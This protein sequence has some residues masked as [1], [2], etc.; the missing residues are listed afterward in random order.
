ML[1]SGDN[2]KEMR[3]GEMDCGPI[4]SEAFFLQK[5]TELTIKRT[6]QYS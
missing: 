1:T 5:M 2:L 3:P 4:S 6:G